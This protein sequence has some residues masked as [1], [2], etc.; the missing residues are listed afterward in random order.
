MQKQ[1]IREV[2]QLAGVSIS[3]FS[4]AFTRPALVSDRAR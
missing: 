4:R 3:T 2:A 1:G